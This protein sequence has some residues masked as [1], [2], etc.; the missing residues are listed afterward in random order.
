MEIHVSTTF[1]GP[2]SQDE[3]FVRTIDGKDLK[4]YKGTFEAGEWNFKLY[5]ED[6]LILESQRIKLTG[7]ET[8]LER[9]EYRIIWQGK[10]IG[11]LKKSYMK[12]DIIAGNKCYPFPILFRPK[13]SSLNLTFPF[14]TWIW[15]RKI[16]SYCL[17]TE[18]KLIML[19]IAVTIYVWFT[20]NALPAD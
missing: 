19:S 2:L 3:F 7:K 4:E 9:E 5:V 14:S 11:L 13:I 12:K 10:E 20:W 1:L 17:A 8:F 15:R 6:K 16:R 18:P